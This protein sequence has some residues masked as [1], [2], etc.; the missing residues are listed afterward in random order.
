[1]NKELIFF[2]WIL[3]IYKCEKDGKW[4]NYIKVTSNPLSNDH[5]MQSGKVVKSNL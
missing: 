1:M 5:K 2:Q 3:T 4:R